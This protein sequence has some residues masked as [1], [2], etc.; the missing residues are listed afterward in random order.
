LPISEPL[1]AADLYIV[2][3]FCIFLMIKAF[4]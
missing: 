3:V 1:L 4:I 2:F